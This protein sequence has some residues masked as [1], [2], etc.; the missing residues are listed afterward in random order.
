MGLCKCTQESS[1]HWM[2]ACPLPRRAGRSWARVLYLSE[3]RS[4]K[5]TLAAAGSAA[6]RGGRLR[7]PQ[8]TTQPLVRALVLFPPIA[9]ESEFLRVSER[10]R[11]GKRDPGRLYLE[12][13]VEITRGSDGARGRRGAEFRA[14][15]KLKLHG[16]DWL[17]RT[18]GRHSLGPAAG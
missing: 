12:R 7:I 3:T 5:P 16:E 8:P 14:R 17:F 13:R 10:P 6:L 11:R 4:R 9:S 2:I 1:L 18:Q 15:G